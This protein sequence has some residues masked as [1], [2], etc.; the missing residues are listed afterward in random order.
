MSD[1]EHIETL[2][3]KGPITRDSLRDREVVEALWEVLPMLDQ[4]QIPSNVQALL[5]SDRVP[6]EGNIFLY[7][8]RTALIEHGLL[9]EKFRHSSGFA[10][11]FADD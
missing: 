11:G 7:E 9:D 4:S 8:I 1:N 5:Q 2:R 3:N 6:T 10:A